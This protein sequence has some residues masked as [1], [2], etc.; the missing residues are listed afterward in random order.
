MKCPRC[1]HENE[2]GA[3]FCEECATPLA[4]ACAKCGRQLS[5][6]ARFCP[7]CAHPTGLSAAP[8]PAPRFGSPESYTPR[9]LAER[10]LTSKAALEGECKQVTVLFA[11]L[12]GSMELLA[13][14]DPEEARKLLDPVLEP[15]RGGPMR[16]RQDPESEERERLERFLEWRRAAG[17][18]RGA[19]DRRSLFFV[20]G[21]LA[22]GVV[23]G[24]L[25]VTLTG[26]SLDTRR[27]L[28]SEPTRAPAEDVATPSSD[29]LSA[30]PPSSPGAGVSA[31]LEPS[32]SVGAAEA[33]AIDR[34]PAEEYPPVETRR[35]P[36]IEP[37]APR[38]SGEPVEARAL[39][40][41]PPPSPRPPLP[42]DRAQPS[43]VTAAASPSPPPPV[44]APHAPPGTRGEAV[45]AAAPSAASSP[46][47]TVATPT[48]PA[49]PG[50][51]IAM[52][53]R[54]ETVETLKRLIGYIPEVRLGKAIARWVK[55]QPPVD[56]GSRPLK[57]ES[58]QAQ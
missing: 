33:V 4:K 9:H 55:S 37:R 12:K 45:G 56:P 1:Q 51:D 44:P 54:S 47:P 8:P 43:D 11:D 20:V 53:P 32:D 58:P 34:A 48:T 22:L 29:S 40:Q 57:P 3:K 21:T 16:D 7:E 10:I 17:R 6:A 42:K 25:I 38:R 18:N 36:R 27:P 31:S 28:A 2:A 26:R 52:D 50:P 5:P 49:V 35:P 14:R 23:A 24:V 39:P 46:T 13:D 30:V 41:R 15:M 19:P